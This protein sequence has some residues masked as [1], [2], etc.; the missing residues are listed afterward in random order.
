MNLT[1]LAS[2]VQQQVA[3]AAALGDERT[4]QIAATLASAADAAVRLALIEAASA[5]CEDVN[6]ALAEAAHGGPCP[7]VS[8]QVE[9]SSLQVAVR[10]PAPDITDEPRADDSDA[11][12]RISLRLS[13]SLKADIEQAAGQADLSVNS[14]LIRAASA[15]IAA[16]NRGGR[17]GWAAGDWQGAGWPG[18]GSPSSSRVT[19]WITG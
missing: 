19:G 7:S 16:A 11:S 2:T 15:G 3:N 5:V 10:G 12:A 8:V 6:V 14:W 9:G 1:L 4:Q 13:E 18:G 17:A